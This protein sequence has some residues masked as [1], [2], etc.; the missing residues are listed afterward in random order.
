MQPVLKQEH[1]LKTIVWASTDLKMIWL[2][3]LVI[4]SITGVLQD[5]YYFYAIHLFS[6]I[7]ISDDLQR[8]GRALTM[9]ARSLALTLFLMMLFLY[10][11]AVWGNAMERSTPT[12]EN[13]ECSTVRSY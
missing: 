3:M 1:L 2:A 8:V 4:F 7:G 12:F 9:N 5:N 10:I 13:G 11:F 6:I